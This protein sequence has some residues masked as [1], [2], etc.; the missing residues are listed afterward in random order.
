MKYIA[1]IKFETDRKLT[2]KEID[3]L[4]DRIGLEIDEPQMWDIDGDLRD[5]TYQT[6][7]ADVQLFEKA[8]Q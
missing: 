2:K 7:N 6:T 4:S 3:A 5:V 8:F 1:L